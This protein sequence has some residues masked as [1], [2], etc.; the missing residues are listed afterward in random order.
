MRPVPIL[1]PVKRKVA[2]ASRVAYPSCVMIVYAH[3]DQAP[4]KGYCLPRSRSEWPPAV[5]M[6]HRK[7]ARLSREVV[8]MMDDQ[9]PWVQVAR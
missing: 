8:G 1:D 5:S 7:S 2:Y 6:I 3:L 4:R 9:R